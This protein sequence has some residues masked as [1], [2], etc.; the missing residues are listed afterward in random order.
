MAIFATRAGAHAV[1]G[2]LTNLSPGTTPEDG[3]ILVWNDSVQSFVPVPSYA[4]QQVITLGD[5]LSAVTV[6]AGVLNNNLRL[7]ELVPGVGINLVQTATSITVSSSEQVVTLG[8]GSSLFAQKVDNEY[9]FK[10]L[11]AGNNMNLTSSS[12][13]L[14]LDTE[15]EVNTASNVGTGTGVFA[16]KDGAELQFKSLVAGPGISFLTSGTEIEIGLVSRPTVTLTDEATVVPNLNDGTNFRIILGADREF[17]NPLNQ[18]AGQSG[19]IRI[20]QGGAGGWNIT[21][22]ASD[23][24]FING[25]PTLPASAGEWGVV[26]YQIEEPGFIIANYL[27]G[28]A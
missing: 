28:S 1:S 15:A 22:W 27:G 11:V 5:T 3:W 20:I 14:V 7:R 26:S 8:S 4:I 13:S 17:G 6:N 23:W 2:L 19:I 12:T 9:Q 10:S 21:S 24:N 18:K 25:G 16:G